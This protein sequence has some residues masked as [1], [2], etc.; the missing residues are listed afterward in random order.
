VCA[1]QERAV[2]PAIGETDRAS[3]TASSPFSTTLAVALGLVLLHDRSSCYFLG[4]A[5]V[6]A[7]FLRALF[8]VLVFTLFFVTYASKM[9]AS[10]HISSYSG[11]K[12]SA[13]CGSQE[14]GFSL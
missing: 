10:W 13:L 1:P 14:M 9:P 2:A 6:T 11:R 7:G 5:A 12:S 3:T 8:D 4:S